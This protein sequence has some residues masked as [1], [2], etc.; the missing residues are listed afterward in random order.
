MIEWIIMLVI[1]WN[2]T[3]SGKKRIKWNRNGYKSIAKIVLFRL[4]SHNLFWFFFLFFSTFFSFQMTFDLD[5]CMRFVISFFLSMLTALVFKFVY[6]FSTCRRTNNIHFFLPRILWL[7]WRAHL[8]RHCVQFSSRNRIMIS[9]PSISFSQ[10][11]LSFS[12]FVIFNIHRL[13]FWPPR[14]QECVCE[15]VFVRATTMSL[16]DMLSF[17]VPRNVNGTTTAEQQKKNSFFIHS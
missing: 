9:L 1:R 2:K 17:D 12:F 16:V 4:I 7:F 10:F 11:F 13:V 6:F 5:L 3:K 15:C 8:T 14:E